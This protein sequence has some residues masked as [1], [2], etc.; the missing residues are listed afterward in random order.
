M[1]NL[2]S[3]LIFC[4]MSGVAAAAERPNILFL[5]ADDQRPDT[6]HALSLIHI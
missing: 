3:I 6:I 1:T 4:F 2:R 5:L